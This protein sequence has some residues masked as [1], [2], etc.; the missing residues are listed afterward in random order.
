MDNYAGQYGSNLNPVI[1]GTPKF[2]SL[3]TLFQILAQII[4]VYTVSTHSEG[5]LY[6]LYEYPMI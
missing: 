3:R 5:E 1:N 6:T 4:N 2:W